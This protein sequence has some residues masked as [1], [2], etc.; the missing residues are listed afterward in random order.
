MP[1]LL[2][3]TTNSSKFDEARR[4]LDESG[5]EILGLRDFSKIEQVPETGATF[6]ENAI[7]KAKGYFAQTGTPC[8]ADDG[9]LMVD[10]LDGAPGVSSHRWL[11]REASDQ[12]LA[13][14]ILDKLAGVAHERRTARLGGFVAFFDGE[15]LITSQN[16]IEGYI[17]DRIIGDMKPGFPYRA[18][19]MIPQFGKPYSELT[20]EKH[21][22][23][24]FRRKNLCALKPEML[25]LLRTAQ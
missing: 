19:L 6:E 5:I 22:E 15:H 13:Q 25:Q 9:G 2:I 4:A 1:R 11:G 18:I 7:L 21:E 16:W 8:V 10:Y 17:A 23:V 3:A 12:E 20:E 24:N 14:A